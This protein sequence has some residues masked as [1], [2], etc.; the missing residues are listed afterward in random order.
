MGC[1]LPL[2]EDDIMAANTFR[3]PLVLHG[4]TAY[5][6]VTRLENGSWLV[7]AKVDGRVLGWER[8][9]LRV[10]V[11]RYRTRVQQWLTWADARTCRQ[12]AAA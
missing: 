10:Q 3:L 8:F 5:L 4:H 9:P 11:D 1:A 2:G 7:Y 12:L 6:D